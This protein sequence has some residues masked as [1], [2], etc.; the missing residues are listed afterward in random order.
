MSND[1]TLK[2]KEDLNNHKEKRLSAWERQMIT[3]LNYCLE[4]VRL[5]RIS[6]EKSLRK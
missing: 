1:K 4:A 6:Q 2:K 3:Y 5:R